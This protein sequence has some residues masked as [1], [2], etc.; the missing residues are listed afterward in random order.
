[1]ARKVKL[2]GRPNDAANWLLVH[3][4]LY[5]DLLEAEAVDHG[6]ER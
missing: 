3:V 2:G 4:L 5:G 6:W 1:M